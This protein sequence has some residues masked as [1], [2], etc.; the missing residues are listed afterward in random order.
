MLGDITQN[1]S[2]VLA[3]SVQLHYSAKSLIKITTKNR[4][5]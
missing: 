4:S 2:D 1:T 5:K 3:A